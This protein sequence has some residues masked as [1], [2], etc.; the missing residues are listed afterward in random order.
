MIIR[1]EVLQDSCAKI[2]GAVD[3]NALSAITETLEMSAVNKMLTLS[4]TNRDY[5]VEVKLPIDT[6]E[7]L[8]ATVNANLFLRLISKVTS[9]TIELSVEDRS[10]NVKCNGLYKFALIYDGDSLMHLP[11]IE[12]EDVTETVKMD[13]SFLRS[14][15]SYNSK[16]LL[17]GTI[18][19]PIQK[20][21][22]VDSDGAI[23]FTTGA[24][25][26]TFDTGLTSKILLS[27]KLVKLMKL[28]KDGDVDVT[29]GRNCLGNDI[30]VTS[31]AFTAPNIMISAVLSSDESMTVGF[32]VTAIRNR[33]LAEY[34]YTVSFNKDVFTQAVDRLML[35]NQIGV[36]GS[37]MS[38]L[39][40]E[41]NNCGVVIS[42]KTDTNKEEIPFTKPNESISNYV[43]YI[44]SG[45]LTKTLASCTNQLVTCAFGNTQAFV[46]TE[47]KVKWVIPEVQEY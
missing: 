28:F 14:L 32:P 35:F 1:T 2:L 22:Y 7:T 3:S 15:V 21:Y 44:D 39:K 40:M 37:A 26:N 41:F 5:F 4:I 25:V 8:Y 23:T 27:D 30:L 31:V 34:P 20:L 18:S 46:L 11:R 36:A 45:D 13:S 9:E 12:V 19:K 42:D 6:D 33:A 43:A 17:K 10:L 16:E 47:G 24:C 38:T 29:I